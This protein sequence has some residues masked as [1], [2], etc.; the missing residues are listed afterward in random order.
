MWESWARPIRSYYS[1]PWR[2][3]RLLGDIPGLSV[4]E[5]RVIGRLAP[6]NLNQELLSFLK[7][8][9]YLVGLSKHAESHFEGVDKAW[10]L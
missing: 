9:R 10:R 4:C 8:T 5:T 6:Q 1:D 2:C 7:T 3:E